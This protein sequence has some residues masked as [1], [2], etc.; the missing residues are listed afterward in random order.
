MRSRLSGEQR[1]WPGVKRPR[2]ASRLTSYVGLSAVDVVHFA[3]L[4]LEVARADEA[5]EPDSGA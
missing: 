3:T 1:I 5:V 2:G 4:A